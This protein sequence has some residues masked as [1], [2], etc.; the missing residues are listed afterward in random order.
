MEY[1]LNPKQ[2]LAT[3]HM[4]GPMLVLAGPGSGKT[5]VITCRIAHLLKMGVSP[6]KILALT[7]TNKAADEMCYRV[8]EMCN[9]RS[10]LISTFHS[11]G[12]HILRESSSAVG[13]RQ[14]FTIY[15]EGDSTKILK[16]C[17]KEA[18]YEDREGLLKSLRA[19][20]SKA[21]NDLASQQNTHTRFARIFQDIFARYQDKLKEYNALDFD[22]LLYLSV[23]A[24]KSSEEVLRFYQKRWKFVLIDEYQDTNA[25]QYRMANL[26]VG[27]HNNLFVVGDPDQ[28]IYSWRGANIANILDFEKD[29]KDAKMVTLDQNYRSSTTILQ[30]A[31][32]LIQHNRAHHKKP[33]WSKLGEGEKIRLFIAKNEQ[34]EAL[35]VVEELLRKVSEKGLPLRECVIFYR[36]NSQSRIFEDV[37]LKSQL[38]YIMLGGISFYQRQEI[39]Y[40]LAL[41][42]MVISES[43]FISFMRTVNLPRRGIGNTTLEKLKNLAKELDMPILALCREGRCKLTKRG[44]AG[45]RD[46]LN[47]IDSLRRMAE[48]L[49]PLKEIIQ[50]AI[51]LSGYEQVLKEDPESYE[52]RKENLEALVNKAVE[53]S[54]ERD[55]SSLF[56]FLEELYLKSTLDQPAR[57]DAVRLMTLHSGKG[58][59]FSLVFIVGMEED[60]FPHINTK[61]SVD[62]LEEERRLCYVGMTRAKYSLYLTTATSRFMWG[63][64]KGMSPSRFLG[65]IP[66]DLFT[67]L[68]EKG[69]TKEESR[70]KNQEH[71]I[72]TVVFHRDFG[73]G[74]IKKV[75]QTSFGL[76]YDVIFAEGSITRSLV[77]EY[78]ELQTD[79][80]C[81]K[82]F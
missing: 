15:D 23:E 22:D 55:S 78:A 43:D 53:W 46:Y 64:S 26:L 10:I 82:A 4:E 24:M 32:A 42:R 25:S 44:E 11:L 9:T 18:G 71:E 48:E 30:A 21:K 54:R 66:S 47:L 45:L 77:N 20:I 12:A 2:Q 16:S 28:S 51:T 57:Q 58:L 7:F 61:D 17:L 70:S 29:Y 33:L 63:E 76:T 79:P 80:L 62:T 68:N 39:K 14:D 49:T 1:S 75:Y 67:L 74:V 41:L 31:N 65:E 34:Q 6:S 60:L 52:E 5:R 36:T 69:A 37:C 38:P 13:Y 50:K 73:R 3:E 35:F 8:G 19:A 72:G 40:I 59:E 27:D 56:L 81:P